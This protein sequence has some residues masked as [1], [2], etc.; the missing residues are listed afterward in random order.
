MPLLLVLAL[1]GARTFTYGDTYVT[2]ES[3]TLTETTKGI[4]ERRIPLFGPCETLLPRTSSSLYE[5]RLGDENATPPWTHVFERRVGDPLPSR[6]VLS[7]GAVQDA[8]KAAERLPTAA[9]LRV[10]LAHDQTNP[11]LDFQLGKVLLRDGDKDGASKAFTAVL[12]HSSDYDFDLVRLSR[13]LEAFDQALADRAFDRGVRYLRQHGYEPELTLSLLAGAVYLGKAGAIDPAA[14]GEWHDRNAAR[15]L[16]FAPRSEGVAGYFRWLRG[17][18]TDAEK[19]TIYEAAYERARDVELLGPLPWQAKRAGLLLNVLMGGACFLALL[20]IARGVSGRRTQPA[21]RWPLYTWTLAEVRGLLLATAVM[22]ACGVSA[23]RG[24][25]Y[26]GAAA[27][28]PMELATGQYD[29]PIAL[30]ALRDL[31]GSDATNRFFGL[32]LFFAGRTDEAE[33][34]FQKL[35]DA[36]GWNNRGVAALRRGDATAARAAFEK[37]LALDAAS[38]AAFNLTRLDQKPWSEAVRDWRTF[39]FARADHYGVPY[40]LALPSDDDYIAL[41]TA[42]LSR[43]KDDLGPIAIL[44]SLIAVSGAAADLPQAL[45]L[46]GWGFLVI[47]VLVGLRLFV[48]TPAIEAPRLTRAIVASLLVPGAEPVYGLFSGVL[49]LLTGTLA[50]STILGGD[51]L[52]AIAMPSFAH[53]FLRTDPPV[54][55]L[56]HAWAGLA[57]VYVINA[58]VVLRRRTA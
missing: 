52:S 50:L 27:G 35:D 45:A 41:Q 58:I 18:T 49:A 16:D 54:T 13:E 20:A 55:L 19:K 56:T 6:Y 33:H 11:W 47:V 28:V 12:E 39:R 25:A 44:S 43:Q 46:V 37:A 22:V 31:H 3:F 7:P 51:M 57:V 36:F 32:S 5:V 17:N 10:A 14:E 40:L 38:P 15:W 4:V 48:A 53:F 30:R 1:T 21:R 42:R 24:I 9:E 2:C 23:V 26:I 34:A 8:K 29:H